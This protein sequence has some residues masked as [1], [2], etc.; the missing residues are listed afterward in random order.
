MAESRESAKPVDMLNDRDLP[1][2][3]ATGTVVAMG[4]SVQF[5][6]KVIDTYEKAVQANASTEDRAGNI[7][8]L[9][10]TTVDDVMVAGDLHGHRNNFNAIRKIANL[11]KRPKRH[12]VIQEVCHGGPTYP[13]SGGC[14]SH[15]MLEDVAKLK[16]DFPNRVHF[17]L[18][19][20]ELAELT[21]F[22]IIKNQKM[23]NLMFRFGMQEMYGAAADK[24]RDASLKFIRTC[25]LA[26]RLE[27]GIWIS[28]TIPEKVDSK[29]FDVRILDEELSDEQLAEGGSAFN[30][31]WGRDFRQDNADAFASLVE[32]NILINGHE[33]AEKGFD[34]P[35]TRQIILDS[36]T[37]DGVY[38]TIPLGKKLQQEDI[39]KRIKHLKRA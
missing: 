22:P 7:V 35:N 12:L 36:H 24:V 39:V 25:P 10:S 20:H 1:A 26:L 4:A 21:D 3:P 30:F 23:L 38:V 15:T 28:H 6:E 19:N 34:V 5:I 17:L 13:N 33:P 32:S 31:L 11:A 16:V 9:F 29:S 27:G 8:E 37:D 2:L 14:M 18:S